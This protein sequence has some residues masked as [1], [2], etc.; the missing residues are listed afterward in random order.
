MNGDLNEDPSG[1]EA[2]VIIR[3]IDPVL[4]QAVE[5]ADETESVILPC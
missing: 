5:K 1:V 2:N 4:I 3:W